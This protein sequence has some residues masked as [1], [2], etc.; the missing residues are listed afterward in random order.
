[1]PA[2]RNAMSQIVLSTCSQQPLEATV[3]KT[4]PLVICVLLTTLATASV[5]AAASKPA[6]TATPPVTTQQKEQALAQYVQ[7]REMAALGK[8]CSA[9]DPIGQMAVQISAEER[10]AWLTWQQGDLA[11]AKSKANAAVKQAESADCKTLSEKLKAVQFGSWQM[12]SSW[13]LRG[14]SMLPIKTHPAWFAGKSNLDAHRKSLE[15]AHDKLM[16]FDTAS[17]TASGHMFDQSTP[18]LLSVR[19]KSKET[20]CPAPITNKRQRAYAETVVKLTERYAAAL[21]KADDKAG[22][23]KA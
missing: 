18:S 10:L 6:A 4:A 5:T 17:V 11:M 13:A 19:C 14:F 23:P 16:A 2:R 21:E 9:L 20:G 3:S 12:R 7:I 15:T 1:M 22:I 8:H